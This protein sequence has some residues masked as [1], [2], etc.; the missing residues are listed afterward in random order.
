[1]LDP[2]TKSY[3]SLHPESAA[4]TLARID[5]Q[6]AAEAFNAMPRPLAATVLAAMAPAS[7]ARCL[8]ALPPVVTGEI[9]NR[10]PLPAAV[11]ALRVVE[12]RKL[13][14]ILAHVTRPKAARIRLRLRFSEWVIGAFVE[15]DV[16]TLLPGQR[17]GD[18]LRVLRGAGRPTG[19]TL[20][21]VDAQRRLVGIVDLC[22]LLSS[23]DRRIIRHM[24]HPVA[25]VLNARAAL[26]TVTNHPAWMENDSLPVVNR[27]GIFQGVLRRSRVHQEEA[28]LMN[29]IVERNELMTTRA[30][31]A[32][33]FWLAVGALFVT[34][35]RTEQRSEQDS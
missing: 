35:R 34:P 5:R 29:E 7:A 12:A 14:G 3:L 32:D 25:H 24:M 31:L 26:Q 11:A 8:T 21:V 19:Q 1:M 15:D 23:S 9:L 6:D 17:V 16:T 22:E 27:N 13:N 18:V 2:V 20:P 4:R 30:A 33:I 28:Q 10:T